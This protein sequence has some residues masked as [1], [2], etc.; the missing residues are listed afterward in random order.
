[1]LLFFTAVVVAGGHDCQFL[2]IKPLRAAAPATI[3]TTS[4]K[5]TNSSNSNDINESINQQIDQL[6]DH[7]TDQTNIPA[8]IAVVAVTAVVAVVAFVAVVSAAVV[9]VA[10]AVAMM[11]KVKVKV[12]FVAFRSDQLIK[13]S[14][15]PVMNRNMQK[16]AKPAAISEVTQTVTPKN[17]YVTATTTRNI[18]ATKNVAATTTK[19]S[20]QKVDRKDLKHSNSKL[21]HRSNQQQL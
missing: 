3:A 4:T 16:H 8:A 21:T 20:Q 12:A 19:I 11:L 18:T 2:M 7:P 6:N 9:A 5:A 15:P 10:V 14:I 13:K 17:K 1:M